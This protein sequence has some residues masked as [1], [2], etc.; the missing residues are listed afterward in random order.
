MGIYTKI[1]DVIGTVYFSLKN[2]LI[3]NFVDNKVLVTTEE[4][5]QLVDTM[6][7]IIS[8]KHIDNISSQI[9]RVCENINIENIYSDT[10]E[11]IT[12]IF[13]DKFEKSSFSNGSLY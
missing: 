5:I 8:E 3:D 2:G 13:N 1:V 11:S 9:F 10:G 7:N 12:N 4:T 6:G